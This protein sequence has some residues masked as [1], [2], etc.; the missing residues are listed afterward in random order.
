MQPSDWLCGSI[1]TAREREAKQQPGT[2]LPNFTVELDRPMNKRNL[3]SKSHKWPE[4]IDIDGDGNLYFSD[5][6]AKELYRFSRERDGSLKNNE[7]LL[8]KGF[9]HIG[10][11]SID[12]QNRLLYLGV[13]LQ[14]DPVS[15]VLQIPLGLL[16]RCQDYKYS[17]ENLKRSVEMNSAALY[18]YE[19]GQSRPNGVVFDRKTKNVFYTDENIVQGYFRNKRGHVGDTQ[20]KIKKELLTPNGIDIDPAIE[21]KTVLVV[22]QTRKNSILR[23]T[24]PQVELVKSQQL[25][26]VGGRLGVG[27]DGL[28][29]LENG[30]ILVA[31][32]LTGQILYLPRD[33]STYSD[34]IVIEDGLDN[35][36]DMVVGPSSSGADNSDSLYVTTLVWWR[37]LLF[38]A[39]K[40]VEI[41]G[42]ATRIADKVIT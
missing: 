30:G 8:L 27:P 25:S 14:E 3:C 35:P 34:P 16:N 31:A 21:D 2:Y 12:R 1:L 10:G 6:V 5:A 28:F 32:F 40:V 39:G 13:T 19:I 17:Y 33:G 4:A 26:G 36:T 15:K 42:I 11:I 23:I 22:G 38:P 24:L 9:K 41:P 18:E 37:M 7:E 29:C 20:G